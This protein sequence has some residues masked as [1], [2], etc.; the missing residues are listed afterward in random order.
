MWDVALTQTQISNNY[1]TDAKHHYLL[2]GTLTDSVAVGAVNL[3]QAGTVV[4]AS[5]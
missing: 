1:L 5:R 3:S 2:D 4:F